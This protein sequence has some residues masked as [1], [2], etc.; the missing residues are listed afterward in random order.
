MPEALI[1]QR[2][3]KIKPLYDENGRK[4][5]QIVSVLDDPKW[6]QEEMDW[7]ASRKGARLV[8]AGT[9][10]EIAEKNWNAREFW[11]DRGRFHDP[12]VAKCLKFIICLFCKNV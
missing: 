3:F 2:S 7:W 4:I 10:E 9:I 5:G 8:I 6:N 12:P 1:K 11:H